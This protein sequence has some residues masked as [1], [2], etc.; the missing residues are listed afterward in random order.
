MSFQSYLSLALSRLKSHGFLNIIVILI[1]RQILIE[2]ERRTH[3]R[4]PY[5]D[6]V[7]SKI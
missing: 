6:Q 7:Y 3:S 5:L 1:Y 2:A 4:Y